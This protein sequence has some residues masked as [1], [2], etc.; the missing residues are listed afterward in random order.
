MEAGP[1]FRGL[2]C[3]EQGRGFRRWAGPRRG[4]AERVG[5]SRGRAHALNRPEALELHPLP[6]LGTSKPGRE[7]QRDSAMAPWGLL[8]STVLAGSVFMGGAV[9]SPLVA[10]GE[11]LVRVGM[12]SEL[13]LR[14]EGSQGLDWSG[15]VEPTAPP[16]PELRAPR[17]ATGSGSEHLGVP[18]CPGVARDGCGAQHGSSPSPPACRDPAFPPLLR[19]AGPQLG[20]F[21]M[22]L[23]WGAFSPAVDPFLLSWSSKASPAK[24]SRGFLTPPHTS[25]IN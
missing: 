15:P 11:C 20:L 9:S 4:Q 24:E 12:P 7:G 1:G 6:G 25:W 13:G 21:R 17:S 8:G 3:G 16:R 19:T 23:S 5:A 18:G 22:L 2:G 10:P 14:T